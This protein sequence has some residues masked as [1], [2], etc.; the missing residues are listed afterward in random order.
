MRSPPM[1]PNLFK[2]LLKAVDKKGDK[3]VTLDE[4]TAAVQRAPA[5]HAALGVP[6][7]MPMPGMG[8]PLPGGLMPTLRSWWCGQRA[9]RPLFLPDFPNW[10]RWVKAPT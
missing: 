1:S 3:K 2:A 10:G 5:C 4:F 6:G 9:A 8:M 7:G